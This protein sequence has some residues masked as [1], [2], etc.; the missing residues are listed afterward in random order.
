MKDKQGGIIIPKDADVDT[1]AKIIF[2]K[3]SK[4]EVVQS[5]LEKIEDEKFLKNIVVDNKVSQLYSKIAVRAINSQ[6]ILKEIAIENNISHDLLMIIVS[7]IYNEEYL[8]ELVLNCNDEDVSEVAINKI[9]DWNILHEIAVDTEDTYIRERSI[10]RIYETS[11]ASGLIAAFI[12]RL[13]R[14]TKRKDLKKATIRAIKDKGDKEDR[15]LLK[16][17]SLGSI[18]SKE[19]IFKILAAS[20]IKNQITLKEV[21]NLSEDDDVRLICLEKIEDFVFLEDLL[22]YRKE[23][24]GIVL[25]IQKRLKKIPKIY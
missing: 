15:K 9:R 3:S 8:K 2:I 5:F 16:D 14:E 10:E 18:N 13:L 23:A 19:K 22:S 25:A 11:S 20:K 6:K 21:V 1:V 24:P 4:K 7:R 17:L 12:Y